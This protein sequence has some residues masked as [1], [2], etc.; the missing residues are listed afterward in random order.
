MVDEAGQIALGSLSLVMGALSPVGRL[1]V[2]GDS[3]QLA[4]ILSAQYPHSRE[5]CLFGSILDL[6]MQGREPKIGKDAVIPAS[7]ASESVGSSDDLLMPQGTVIQLTENFRFAS[8][9]LSKS[10][11]NDQL[12]GRLNPDLGEFISTI[13]SRQFKSQKFQAKHMALRLQQ[14]EEAVVEHLC[15]SEAICEAIRLFFVSLSSVM[16]RKSQEILHPPRL[17]LPLA[18]TTGII[19]DLTLS[20]QPISLALIRLRMIPS[21]HMPYEM[22]VHGEAAVAASLVEFIR[23][24][25]PHDDIF[26]A[27]PHR[28]QREAVKNVLEQSRRDASH[29]DEA[30]GNLKLHSTSGKVTVDTIE[31]LQGIL[32][33]LLLKKIE[34]LFIQGSEAAFVICLFSLPQSHAVDLG[35][36]L[37]RRR[38][39]VAISRA[40]SLCILV[41]SDEV[42]QPP[43]RVLANE[44]MVKGYTFLKAYEA[45]AWSYDL[46]VDL[47]DLRDN[48]QSQSQSQ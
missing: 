5:Q 12:L 40:K 48:F 14:A 7:R 10:E 26:V 3:E 23:K 45:R 37:Q 39:N 13:Y 15:V 17:Q 16:L 11:C 35:F 42:L 33:Q 20:H 32:I 31:R 30:F 36:L 24:C 27:T 34:T 38:L 25:S 1:V 41:T 8:V 43:V 22:H 29:L 21:E 28:I 6:L 19:T 9:P 4:P 47:D 44:D 46:S 18:E 2:A